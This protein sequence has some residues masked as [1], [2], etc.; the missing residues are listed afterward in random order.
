M[1]QA[2]QNA[3]PHKLAVE[4]KIEGDNV[5][6]FSDVVF[7][8]FWNT[9]FGGVLGDFKA[10]P[11]GFS[12]NWQGENPEKVLEAAEKGLLDEAVAA[13]GGMGIFEIKDE[14][15]SLYQFV[16]AIKLKNPAIKHVAPAEL[17]AEKDKIDIV[18]LTVTDPEREAVLNFMRPWPGHRE[19]LMGPIG[20]TTYRF[21]RFGNY[22]AAQVESTMSTSGSQG[23]TLT[24][25]EAMTHLDPK[26]FLLLGIAF[27]VDRKKQ[28]LGDV[29][30][31]NSI[32][33]YDYS[34]IG[35]KN[36][37]RRGEAI[38]CGE[39]LSER[40][41]T[42]RV[43]WKLNAGGRRVKVF[44]GLVLSGDKLINDQEFR[45]DLLQE[46]PTAHGGEMEGHGAYAVAKKAKA[47]M[48]LIKAICDWADG[49][50]N[51]R[52]QPFAAYT[53]ASLAS[54]VLGKP[55]VLDALDA[56]DLTQNPPNNPAKKLSTKS[57]KLPPKAS[58]SSKRT[59]NSTRSRQP[60]APQSTQE[61]RNSSVELFYSYAHR[62]EK[63]RNQLEIYLKL[64]ERQKLITSW[65]DRRITASTE[66][67]GAIDS[68]L[69]SAQIILLLVS[70]DFLASDYIYDVELKQ[71][72]ERHEA[73][74]ARI[75][76]IILR[77]C[78]WTTS[79]F[80]KLQ[81]LPK[82]AKPVTK[83]ANRDEAWANIA[84]GIRAVIQEIS[85]Q[86]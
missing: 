47:E 84:A 82:D 17:L 57:S 81:A 20:D 12:F 30:V 69:Q 28:R 46:F 1:N 40:F 53:A 72:M 80:S 9:N 42:Y 2:E 58:D 18:I 65:H 86:S 44:Q 77:P 35:G 60:S 79:P 85:R 36:V 43:N 48:I 75:I 56:R 10:S 22:C 64:L 24:A 52:A 74:E 62:D 21:G 11:Q 71:A 8:R 67:A 34:K 14:K 7:Q 59:T 41:R 3:A 50:K 38:P 73:G 19:I 54:Y 51:D 23:A 5:A 68:H 31:A 66:W 16:P 37:V 55:G 27:G 32:F 83:W 33:P 76:P 61:S 13:N 39:I 70:A 25:Q 49:H 29:L 78:D 15:E 26:A 6:A 63:F 4:I 45:D